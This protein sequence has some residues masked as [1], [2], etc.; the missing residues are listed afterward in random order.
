[1]CVVSASFKCVGMMFSLLNCTCQLKL[2]G[3]GV[4][5]S[6]LC[7]S[8]NYSKLHHP[9]NALY[10]KLHCHVLFVVCFPLVVC[11]FLQGSMSLYVLNSVQ[12]FCIPC[13]KMLY[14]FCCVWSCT[15]MVFLVAIQKFLSCTLLD[16]GNQLFT[17][18]L[19][20]LE[21]SSQGSGWAKSHVDCHGY[22][23]KMKFN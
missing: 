13:F 20:W 12:Y 1:M 2:I 22:C 11:F 4:S 19:F 5:Y 14:F 7:G 18:S 3:S 10:M 21:E 17:T 16:I 15:K 23:N 9:C 8:P 6:L